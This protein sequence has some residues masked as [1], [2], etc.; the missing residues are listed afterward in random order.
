MYP[1]TIQGKLVAS[2]V[3]LWGIVV[4]SLPI[5]I[6]GSNFVEAYS[7]A[8][9]KN[10]ITEEYEKKHTTKVNCYEIENNNQQIVS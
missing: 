2:F 3:F 10:D 8:K 7:E 4:I 9:Y 5:A 6:I 1:V